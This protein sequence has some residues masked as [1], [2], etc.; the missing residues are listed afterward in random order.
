MRFWAWLEAPRQLCRRWWYPKL[1][2]QTSYEPL[3]NLLDGL[4]LAMS[5]KSH[6]NLSKFLYLMICYLYII[7][8]Y[9][10]DDPLIHVTLIFNL[11]HTVIFRSKSGFP[12][13]GSSLVTCHRFCLLAWWTEHLVPQTNDLKRGTQPHTTK[14]WTVPTNTLPQTNGEK[15]P[16]K[17]AETCRN[18]KWK[19]DRLQF[20]GPNSPLVL[21]RVMIFQQNSPSPTMGD[22][23]FSLC[24]SIVLM[25]EN[26][27]AS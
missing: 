10:W 12:K 24:P 22:C 5:T 27:P 14:P 11:F 15:I 26:I 8:I 23:S 9:M 4:G 6:F 25:K 1:N 2:S 7:T 13:E 3:H 21:G 20:S 19:P 18:P 17:W 16:W